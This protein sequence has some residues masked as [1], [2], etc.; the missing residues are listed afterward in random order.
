MASIESVNSEYREQ[1]TSRLPTVVLVLVVLLLV[2]G[3]C[4][5]GFVVGRFLNPASLGALTPLLLGKPA[6]EGQANPDA[7]TPSAID[8]EDLFKPFWQAWDIVHEDYVEQPVDDIALMRGAISGMLEA[9]GDEH[10]SYL[11][12]DMTEMFNAHLQGQEYE[13]IGAWIDISGDYLTIISPMP[14]SPAEKAGLQPGDQVIAIDGQDM[15]G[16]DGEL[17][18][19]QVLGPKGS[20]VRLTILR[21]GVDEPFDVDVIRD[22]ILVPTVEG[23]MVD[24]IAYV[25]LATFGD[26]TTKE[27]RKTL[28]E[29]L[30]Q[31]PAGMVLDLRNNGG[32]YLHVAIDVVS[33][34]IG[35]GTVMIEEYGD[36]KQ[37]I[38]HWSF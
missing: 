29:L 20:T 9:L 30:A 18:R 33:E 13:G 25:H 31:K 7:G 32:G 36:G 28:K 38:S 4:S 19:K 14:G 27:L 8:R 24:D 35:D 22:A 37:M 26:D 34:F 6:A 12:P 1:K 3:A 23:K 15:T 10:T 17:V 11:D 21:K 5:A 2:S 16:I